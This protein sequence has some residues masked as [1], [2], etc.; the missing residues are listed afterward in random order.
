MVDCVL[1]IVV[2]VRQ[3]SGRGTQGS[4]QKGAD[5]RTLELSRIVLVALLLLLQNQ[6]RFNAKFEDV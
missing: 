2:Q 6:L 4:L 1:S 5:M 3:G